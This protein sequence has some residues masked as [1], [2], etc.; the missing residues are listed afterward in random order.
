ME[1][2][3]TPA[4][5]LARDHRKTVGLLRCGMIDETA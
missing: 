1:A 2:A 5:T 4:P 3:A